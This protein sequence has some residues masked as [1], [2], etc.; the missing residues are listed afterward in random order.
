M[1]R[2]RDE[3]EMRNGVNERT[4]TSWFCLLKLPAMIF[5]VFKC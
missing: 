4:F 5:K 2:A 3:Q 1:S